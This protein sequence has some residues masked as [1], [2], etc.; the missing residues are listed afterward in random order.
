VAYAVPAF[1][2]TEQPN[3]SIRKGGGLRIWLERPW[4]VSGYGELCAVIVSDTNDAKANVNRDQVS[5]WGSDPA[6]NGVRTPANLLEKHVITPGIKK[7]VVALPDGTIVRALGHE[8]QFSVEKN[9]WYCDIDLAAGAAYFPFVRLALARL[10]PGA[11]QGCH[12]SKIVKL[13]FV[14]VTATRQAQVTWLDPTQAQVTVT[15]P[16]GATHWGLAHEPQAITAASGH[17]MFARV[18]QRD[19]SA[20]DP[21]PWQ[22][23]AQAQL[24][25]GGIASNQVSWVGT[26]NV[27][28]PPPGMSRRLVVEE[29]EVHAADAHRGTPSAERLVYAAEIPT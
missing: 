16:A 18:E 20:V 22:I 26:L 14:Q 15:G 25:A 12:L 8:V 19:A 17:R 21:I 5:E 27:P 24:P 13:D 7:K 29:R 1:S 4:Y 10:Q 11:I 2:W 9:Q 3:V 6:T 28:A 23:V